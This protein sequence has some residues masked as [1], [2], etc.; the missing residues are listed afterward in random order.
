MHRCLQLARLAI[1]QTAP[2]PLVGSVLVHKDRIIG[3]GFHLQYGKAHAEV[4][5]LA[6]VCKEERGLIKESTLYVSLEPCAHQGKT[7][8]CTD[9]II[10][11][12]IPKVIIGCRDP[13]YRVDGKGIKKLKAAGI[14]VEIG[15]M[16]TECRQLNQDFFCYH[17][18]HR[19]YIILKWAETLSGYVGHK[20]FKR[21]YVSSEASLRRVHQWRSEVMAI[22]VGTNTAQYDDPE[23]TTRYYPGFHPLRLV[24][25]KNLRL[26]LTLKIFNGVVPTLIFNFH[27]HSLPIKNLSVSDLKEVGVAHYRI[28]EDEGLVKQI[29]MALYQIQVQSV[30]V[31]G[32]PQL[33][34]SFI[35]EG[36]WDEARVITNKKIDLS[37]G[38]KAP[39]L[40]NFKLIQ[41][42]E[43]FSDSIT[44]YAPKH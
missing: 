2:N 4:N 12:K 15:I 27:K 35:D 39:R 21:L 1:G 26:P 8:P 9:L 38:L 30:L 19:P 10:E 29:I 11:H 31:E 7:P 43:L 17:T 13:Y 44:L 20:D 16:E 36:L 18:Q 22:L 5:C 34:Q 24:V 3:E 40:K 6:S 42:E 25:D 28:S 14:V 33:L 23:L 32:G 37:D 41:E